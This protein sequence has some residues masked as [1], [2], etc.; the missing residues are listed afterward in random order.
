MGASVDWDRE[1]FT[2]D[3]GLSKAVRKVFVAAYKKGLIYKG[4]RIINWDP[5][6][7]TALSDEEVIYQEKN[8]K[9]YYVKYPLLDDKN[10]FVIIKYQDP[11]QCLAIQL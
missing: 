6:Q 1:R 10:K 5:E 7:Q 8:D 9:L 2:M 4:K 3:E 11:K